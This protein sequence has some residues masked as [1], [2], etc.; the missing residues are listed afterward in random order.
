MMSLLLRK[1]YL[2]QSINQ[3]ILHLCCIVLFAGSLIVLI[4]FLIQ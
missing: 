4:Q 1:V 3:N 2:H